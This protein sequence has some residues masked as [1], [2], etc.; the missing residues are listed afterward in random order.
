MPVYIKDYEELARRYQVAIKD[1]GCA[2]G[3]ATCAGWINVARIL[4][5]PLPA[6]TAAV[7]DF[8]ALMEIELVQ[9]PPQAAFLAI[10]AFDRFGKNRHPADLNFGDCFAYACARHYG[11]PMLLQR[12]RLYAD[13]H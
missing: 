3:L 1:R 13:R 4:G 5:I 8:L 10:E 7:L 2:P 12:Q 11:V 9:I 6:A